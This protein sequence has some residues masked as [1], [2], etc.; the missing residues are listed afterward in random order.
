M[1]DRIAVK[2]AGFPTGPGC[3]VFLDAAG[4]ALYVGKAANLRA[5]VR[6]YLR[7]GGDGRWMLR[8]LAASAAD[9]EF[10]ATNTEQEALLLEDTIVKK[11]QPRFNVKLR[12]DKAFLMLRLDRRE[13]WPWFRLVRRRK[14]DGA[15]YFG[16][17][18]SA[19]SVRRTLA[20]VHKIVPLRDCR[21]AVFRNR[22]RP[23]IKFEIGRCPA[24]CVG[25]IESSDYAALLDRA[26]A[27]LRGG[28]ATILRQLRSEMR[29]AADRLEFE[30][31]GALKAQ[32]EA[33]ERIGEDQHVIHDAGDSDA[34]GI[35][36]DEQG[37]T[38]VSILMFRTGRL[39][40][41]RRFQLTTALP[42]EL[43]L[44]DVITQFYGSDRYV[45]AEIL[46]PIEPDE[47]A[48]LGD[49]LANRRRGP[50]ALKVPQRGAARRQLE[51]ALENAR[52][53]AAAAESEE[54]AREDAAVRLME[55]CGLDSPPSR[56]HCLDVSTTQGR[57]TVASR[58]CFVDGQPEKDGY[59]RFKIS[60][61]AA[62]D[63]FAAMEEAVRRSVKR[64]L[65]ETADLLPDL[66]IVDGG[67]GQLAAARRALAELSLAADLP[68]VGLAKS[69]LRGAG[70]AGARTPERIV[71]PDD[72]GVIALPQ[73]APETL[74]VAAI[75]DEAHRFAITYHRKLRGRL[76][77]VL[78]EIEGLG[79]ARRQLLLRYFGSIEALRAA[80]RSA[81][82]AVPGL[83]EDVA[84][85]VFAALGRTSHDP[86]GA[87]DQPRG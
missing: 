21:D 23:C 77:S 42:E 38:V 57:E 4:K 82:S 81:L 64:C 37:D 8:F 68:I 7:P 49:W 75:R 33:L 85:R 46:V 5:R 87:E 65:G 24:P 74:L 19:K 60:S 51:L 22:S 69:R 26:T 80:D 47:A 2:V 71:L 10:V 12:D 6:S 61:A 76:T 67:A 41:A 35:A 45:P 56:I 28:H 52:L 15:E 73:D 59:R 39:E 84:D 13:E 30:R 48:L 72:R 25:R 36:R 43:L 14:D 62:G 18:A 27:I 31:A 58:V 9:V 54:S 17:F 53:N 50:C 32:I 16:P 55:I 1:D 20:L 29:A 78:D 86:D 34:I 63:D 79:P 40:S 3:Y 70:A 83:P 66:V 44:A 11:R